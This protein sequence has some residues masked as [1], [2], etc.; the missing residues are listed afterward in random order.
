MITRMTTRQ[1]AKMNAKIGLAGLV[2]VAGLAGCGQTSFF[3]VT[4]V[5]ATGTNGIDISMINS[6][7]V[8]V[9][10]AATDSF[11]LSQAK[12]SHV[13]TPTLGT[14]EYGTTAES[15]MLSFHVDL[16]R[17]DLTKLGQGDSSG[18]IKAGGRQTVTVNVQ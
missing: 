13:T 18:A 6:C 4:V 15:G 3:E 16:L 7:V 2:L 8:K 17:G 5:A 11:S 12:C 1:K 9:S 10:G 14:F